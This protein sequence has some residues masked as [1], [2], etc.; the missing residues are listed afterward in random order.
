MLNQEINRTRPQGGPRQSAENGQYEFSVVIVTRNRAGMLGES[1][2]RA[3]AMREA[4]GPFEVIVVDNGSSDATGAVLDDLCG[5]HP[6]RLV[7][8]SEPTPGISRARNAGIKAARGNWLLFL[9]DDAWAPEDLLCAYCR[10]L[11]RY[12]GSWAWGGGATL[13][14]PAKLPPCWGPAFD[15]MLSALD[16]GDAPRVLSFPQTPYGLNMLFCREV[17]DRCGGFREAITFGGDET[18]LFLRMG[19]AGMEVRYA[20]GCMVVHAVEADRFSLRWLL[21]AAFRSGGYHAN[22]DRLNGGLRIG[23]EMISAGWLKTLLGRRGC[24]PLALGM[25]MLRVAGYLATQ[26]REGRV[27]D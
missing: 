18:D 14:Y 5:R 23:W 12:S 20:P 13:R 7:T 27:H 22:L 2:S 6:Q 10:W 11:E 21:G 25:H 17:F 9:D 4:G 19:Q 3:L 24:I 1:V 16:L 26:R 8:I 15:G